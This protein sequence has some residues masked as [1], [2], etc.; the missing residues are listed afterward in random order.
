MEFMS[1]GRNQ[2][3]ATPAGTG[4]HMG[5]TEPSP[6]KKRR[7]E[8][9]WARYLFVVFVG[10]LGILLIALIIW[11]VSGN[12]GNTSQANYVDDSR[13]QAVFLNNNQVYFGK[14]SKLNNDY[15]LLTDVF[16]LQVNQT[17][18]VQPGQSTNNNNNNL[19]L[20]KLGKGELHGPDDTMII[21]A[22][23]V[24]FWEN[25]NNDGKVVDAIKRYKENPDAGGQ[26]TNTNTNSNSNT[27]TNSN[28]TNSS[29]NN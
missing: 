28:N 3:P 17:N 13:Y 23:Q 22:D 10:G 15:M 19:V 16:Y 26:S 6:S 20:Q 29:D 9:P 27:N 24:T 14:I 4:N 2:A 7:V 25:I 5:A 11:L 18:N 8:S 12:G 1:R 21:N